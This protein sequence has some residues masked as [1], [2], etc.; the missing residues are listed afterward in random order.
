MSGLFTKIIQGEIPCHKILEDERFF[1]FLDVKPINPGHTLVIPKREIDY[2]FDND[3]ET[4]GGILIFAK[5]VAKAI[6]QVT[7][8][9]RVGLMVAGLEVPHTHIHLIPISG[10]PD[11]N[12]ANAKEAGQ[13]ELAAMADQIKGALEEH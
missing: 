4:L 7:P 1:A 6:D 3:E 9:K 11:L 13:E 8:Q 2:I 10:I 5:K 12:F